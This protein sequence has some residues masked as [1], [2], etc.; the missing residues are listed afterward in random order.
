MASSDPLVG[1]ALAK[2]DVVLTKFLVSA[3]IAEYMNFWRE[4]ADGQAIRSAILVEAGLPKITY[5]GVSLAGRLSRSAF[6]A[7]LDTA[8][9]FGPAPS[10]DRVELRRLSVRLRELSDIPHWLTRGESKKEAVNV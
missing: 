3:V 8:R 9:I 7:C 10:T 6:L 2:C 4:K 1:R 5:S